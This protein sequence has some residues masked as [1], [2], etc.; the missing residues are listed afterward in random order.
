MVRV[1]DRPA[2]YRGLRTHLAENSE[3]TR[4]ERLAHVVAEGA[5]G[6][7]P[8]EK[9]RMMRPGAASLQRTT[10]EP[11]VT[12]MTFRRSMIASVF[13]ITSSSVEG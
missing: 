8:N 10:S 1:T 6:P 2:P 12:A 3:S 11:L 5:S 7:P 13:C 9:L 4:L